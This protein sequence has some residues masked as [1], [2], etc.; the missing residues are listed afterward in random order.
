[1]VLGWGE[2]PR[3]AERP[4]L[5][6]VDC[7]Q[8]PARGADGIRAGVRWLAQRAYE[9]AAGHP[10]RSVGVHVL[11]PVQ[12]LVDSGMFTTDVYAAVR[13]LYPR[14]RPSKGQTRAGQAPIL[15]TEPERHLAAGGVKLVNVSVGLYKDLIYE[16]L[17]GSVNEARD[18]AARAGEEPWRVTL[19]RP[20][21][22][23]QPRERDVQRA[24]RELTSEHRVPKRV[25]GVPMM[26]WETRPG[27]E[28]NHSLDAMVYGWAAAHMSG[29][30]GL[31]SADAVARVAAARA[32][33]ADGGRM[34]ASVGSEWERGGF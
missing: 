29:V 24:L 8:V 19:P 26:V 6:L 13:D 16:W 27:A 10:Y 31:R 14:V 20:V 5:A 21:R 4:L 32:P 12:T 17:R 22:G 34:K 23:D 15:I 33:K 11:R 25:R 30:L 3:K 28:A 7:G 1:V 9:V 2:D 18:P